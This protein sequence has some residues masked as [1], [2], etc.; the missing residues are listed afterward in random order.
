M[1]EKI[2]RNIKTTARK[3]IY[4]NH[5]ISLDQRAQW[6][7]LHLQ[8]EIDKNQNKGLSNSPKK[9]KYI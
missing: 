9:G 8:T 2:F 6:K 1:E 7:H 4:V 3:E 5:G